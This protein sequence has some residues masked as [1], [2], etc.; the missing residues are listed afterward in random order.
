MRLV[1]VEIELPPPMAIERLARNIVT[2]DVNIF[3]KMHFGPRR[4][5][6]QAEGEDAGEQAMPEHI[7]RVLCGDA[8]WTRSLTA[9]LASSAQFCK[10]FPSRSTSVSDR[11]YTRAP[12]ICPGYRNP[13]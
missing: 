13:T 11:G 9:F 7:E 5:G 3:A 1:V 2:A 6:K 4:R 12:G 8:L 10:R